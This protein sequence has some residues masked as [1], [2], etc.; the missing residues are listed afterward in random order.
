[1]SEHEELAPLRNGGWKR[2][3][4]LLESC[5]QLSS[6][7]FRGEDFKGNCQFSRNACQPCNRNLYGQNIK[8]ISTP[9]VS[10]FIY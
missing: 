3:A 8:V 9:L 7:V 1:V 2:V 4:R 10:C 5:E 6:P